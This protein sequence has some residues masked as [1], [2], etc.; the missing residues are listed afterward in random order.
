M[1]IPFVNEN[2]SHSCSLVANAQICCIIDDQILH[3]KHNLPAT[4]IRNKTQR[5]A[6]ASEPTTET[7]A[8]AKESYNQQKHTAVAFRDPY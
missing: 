3:L 2:L 5:R 1:K 8:A 6:G 7:I 4:T